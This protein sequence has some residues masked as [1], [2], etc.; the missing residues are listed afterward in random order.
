MATARMPEPEWTNLDE[1]TER[2]EMESTCFP[3][4]L[5]LVLGPEITHS[6]S[7]FIYL[8]RGRLKLRYTLPNAH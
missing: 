4:D 2:S 7:F 6:A 3:V 8:K 5:V 1:D